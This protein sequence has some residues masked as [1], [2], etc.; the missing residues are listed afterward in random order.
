MRIG[1]ASKRSG[2]SA[3]LIRHY[4]ATGL[5]RPAERA[6]NGYRIYTP[7]DVH[8][9][10][11][12]KRARS[13]GFSIA[14]IGELL[15]LWRDK[16]RPSRSVRALAQRH[17]AVLDARLTVSDAASGAVAIG[18]GGN[19]IPFTNA[20]YALS[21]IPEPGTALLMGLGLAGYLVRR[22]RT[23]ATEASVKSNAEYLQD[24]EALGRLKEKGILTEQE[25]Q[26]KKKEILERM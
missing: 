16:T 25:F 9:L 23:A 24:L 21:V 20:T 17:L 6:E 2:V 11:F 14:A 7:I 1:E 15:S 10:R 18:A 19:E 26:E 8:E 22:K 12:I 4:E 5:L 13:L 3:K